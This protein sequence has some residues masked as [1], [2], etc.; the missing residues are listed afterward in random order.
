MNTHGPWRAEPRAFR[1][2]SDRPEPQRP[3]R[4]Q[5]HIGWIHIGR[6]CVSYVF[7]HY[8][9]CWTSCYY[10]IKYLIEPDQP[11][12]FLLYIQ[13]PFPFFC[14]RFVSNIHGRHIFIHVIQSFSRLKNNISTSKQLVVRIRPFFFLSFPVYVLRYVRTSINT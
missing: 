12:I 3:L 9:S 11:T 8:D 6:S 2:E 14:C 10:Q 13:H 1:S 5:T 4:W 7:V